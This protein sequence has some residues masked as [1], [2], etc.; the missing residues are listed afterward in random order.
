MDVGE[1][2]KSEQMLT[3][4]VA[5]VT[6][7]KQLVIVVGQEGAIRKAVE[8]IYGDVRLSSLCER[9]QVCHRS[10]TI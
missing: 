9:L 7:A 1:S 4:V 5:A 10:T 3:S 6:R 8:E 2:G